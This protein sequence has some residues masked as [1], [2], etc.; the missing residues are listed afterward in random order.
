MERYIIEITNAL[1]NMDFSNLSRFDEKYY[2]KKEIKAM[3]QDGEE[4]NIIE[5]FLYS[6]LGKEKFFY[7]LDNSEGMLFLDWYKEKGKE[8]LKPLL[9]I[10]EYDKINRTS[11]IKIIT[12]YEILLK[13]SIYEKNTESLL[14]LLITIPKYI[15]NKCLEWGCLIPQ[16]EITCDSSTFRQYKNIIVEKYMYNTCIPAAMQVSLL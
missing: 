1:E 6:Y 3:N 15:Y 10:V 7:N 8:N 11:L 4:K 14:N 12:R 9:D 2:C 13:Q 16:M 5:K